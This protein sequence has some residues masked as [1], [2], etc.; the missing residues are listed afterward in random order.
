MIVWF[1]DVHNSNTLSLSCLGYT[2]PKFTLCLDSEF[3]NY[4]Y[5]KS[6]TFPVQN[7]S[8]NWWLFDRIKD[9]H[10][11]LWKI[12]EQTRVFLLHL[13]LR[14][15]SG[16]IR[17]TWWKMSGLL[18]QATTS[19]FRRDVWRRPRRRAYSQRPH[20]ELEKDFSKARPKRPN[21]N[22]TQYRFGQLS[23]IVKSAH[24]QLLWQ[25]KSA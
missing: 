10:W 13:Q 23:Q 5:L 20:V 16:R 9:E 19:G 7:Q 18:E 1:V 15:H 22:R 25:Q 4:S 12:Q 17:K 8:N 21:S 2:T 6:K 14:N 24:S 3:I 11:K